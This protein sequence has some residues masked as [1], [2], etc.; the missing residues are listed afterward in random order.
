MIVSN[1]IDAYTGEP[2]VEISEDDLG[3]LIAESPASA[4]PLGEL[5]VKPRGALRWDVVPTDVA[6]A[7]WSIVFASDESDEVREALEPLMRHRAAKVGDGH[8]RHEYFPGEDLV[9]WLARYGVNPGTIDPSRIGYYVLLVGSPVRI[10]FEFQYLLD[11]EYAVGRVAFDSPEEYRRYADSVVAAETTGAVRDKVVAYWGTRHPWDRATKLSADQLLRPLVP[12]DDGRQGL[13]ERNGFRSAAVIGEQATKAALLDVLAGSNDLPGL[14][15]T[16]GHGLGGLRADDPEQRPRHGALVTQDWN[17][18]PAGPEVTVAGVDVAEARV[19]GMIAFLFA[20]Y[21]AGT[22]QLDDFPRRG[23]PAATIA[24]EPFVACLPQK[25]L[26]HPE[27]GMLAVIGHVERAWG[28]S[29]TGAGGSQL[30]R[31]E[32]TFAQLIN[33]VPVGHSMRMFN[34]AFAVLS[35]ALTLRLKVLADKPDSSPGTRRKLLTLWMERTDVQNYVVLGDPAVSL[36][37]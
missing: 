2:L 4:D 9:D 33:G 29:I 23:A 14:L 16:A 21:G 36:R 20:C 35:A 26:A 10:P 22:P 27:G 32:D 6:Q 7:G 12:A 13:A 24:T 1:G 17:R 37:Y 5:G 3:E 34:E 19:H 28:Y 15:V 8:H 11:I 25:L 31:F 18:G 30:Q